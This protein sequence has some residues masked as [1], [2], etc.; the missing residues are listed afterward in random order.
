VLTV[1]FVVSVGYF[2]VTPLLALDLTLSLHAAPAVAGVLVGAYVF[3]NQAMQV[4][5]GVLATR[6]GTL[7]TL[8]TS[9]ASALAGYALLAI[10]RGTLGAA[11]G[12]MLAAAGSGGRTVSMKVFVT[13]VWP[14]RGVR[15]LTLRGMAINLAA[16][17]GPFFGVLLLHRFALAFVLAGAANVPLVLLALALRGDVA[18][19]AGTAAGTSW[20]WAFGGLW[21]LLRHPLL[22]HSIAASIGFWLLYAQLSLTVPLYVHRAYHS[23]F[24]LSVMFVLNAVLAALVQGMLLK[25]LKRQFN[26]ARTLALGMLVTGCSFLPLLLPMHGAEVIVFVAVFTFGEAIVAP[27]LDA[28]AALT[29]GWSA[30]TGNAFALVAAGWAIGGL[31]GNGLG[32]LLFTA[33]AEHGRVYLLWLGFWAVG[34]GSAALV[35]RARAQPSATVG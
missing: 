20:R 17:L 10:A 13:S 24:I 28:A 21:A 6:Y 25:R 19:P 5:A 3:V 4:M 7:T 2:M 15:A 35:V 30:S 1:M 9:A 33:T 34:C 12:V 29:A 14:E 31:I 8:L 26:I 23:A 16:A 22:R 32:G 11:A 18:R 27:L